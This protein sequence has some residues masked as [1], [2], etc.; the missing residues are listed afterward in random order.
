MSAAGQHGQHGR[1]PRS[2]LASS[3]PG[4]GAPR[5]ATSLDDHGAQYSTQYASTTTTPRSLGLRSAPIPTPLNNSAHAFPTIVTGQATPLSADL[6]LETDF[7]RRDSAVSKELEF[8]DYT[9]TSMGQQENNYRAAL[10]HASDHMP[11]RS[12]SVKSLS[13]SFRSISPGSVA[14]SPGI[15]PFADITPLPS[16]LGSQSGSWLNMPAAAMSRPLSPIHHGQTGAS[17]LSPSSPTSTRKHYGIILPNLEPNTASLDASVSKPRA[18]SNRSSS[19]FV[20]PAPHSRVRNIVVSNSHPH[21]HPADAASPLTR[22]EYIAPQ[23]GIAT[24]AIAHPPTP[25]KSE[26]GACDSNGSSEN[27]AELPIP[28]SRPT[29]RQYEAY[30]IP[31]NRLQKWVSVRQLGVGTFS[32]VM[33]ATSDL[34]AAGKPEEQLDR[35]TLVAVKICEHGPAGGADEKKIESSLQRELEILKAINHPSLVRLSAVNVLEKRAFL[36]L[37]YAAGGDLFELASQKLSVLTP[38]LVRRMF[39]EL[40]DAVTYLHKNYIVHRDIKLESMSSN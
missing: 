28:K 2:Q 12:S 9:D 37:D 26:I 21:A 10:V 5:D 8:G 24:R 34:A 35:A 1:S 4:S 16:P 40:V 30:T 27:V 22:E 39:A 18:Y 36:V 19:E 29:P 6:H 11:V 7:G 17:G 3:V 32:T 33:L 14:S 15:G 38:A 25:P 13:A 23:R 20:R 31:S